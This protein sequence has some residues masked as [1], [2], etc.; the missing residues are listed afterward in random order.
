MRHQIYLICFQGYFISQYST[1]VGEKLNN[2]TFLI[3]YSFPEHSG[4]LLFFDINSGKT[5]KCG[6]K[7]NVKK[8]TNYKKIFKSSLEQEQNK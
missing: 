1:T 5:L 2:Q 8:E 6:L 7:I 3:C 4:K